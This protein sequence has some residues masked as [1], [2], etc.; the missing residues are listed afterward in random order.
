MTQGIYGRPIEGLNPSH[1]LQADTLLRQAS[2]IYTLRGKTNPGKT[3]FAVRVA[4]GCADPRLLLCILERPTT[5]SPRGSRQRL[6]A[7]AKRDAGRWRRPGHARLGAAH[8]KHT[9][10]GTQKQKAQHRAFPRGPPPQYYPGSNL[11]NFAVR[12]G[13]G[14]PG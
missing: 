14:E 5:H 11:L 3:R 10:K 6:T 13:S 12:M 9:K 8:G 7:L 2:T 4:Q 1:S